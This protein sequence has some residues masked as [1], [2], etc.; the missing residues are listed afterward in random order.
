MTAFSLRKNA[1]PATYPKE[2]RGENFFANDLNAQRV[3][4]RIAPDMLERNFERLKDFGAFVGGPLDEQAAYSD[5]TAPPRLET[6]NKLG[7]KKS[8]VIFNAKY[9][10]AHQE[11]YKRGAIGLSFADKDAEPHLLSFTM[12][13]MLS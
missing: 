8:H 1:T 12:G 11:A 4:E 7:E 9:E 13:Y 10:D 5:R 2:T 6:H 3:L